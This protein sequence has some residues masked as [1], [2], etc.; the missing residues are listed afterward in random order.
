MSEIGR[1]DAGADRRQPWNEDKTPGSKSPPEPR[2]I[3]AIRT[4]LQLEGRAR[5]L[6]LF[7]LAID[8]N[9][10][11]GDVVSLKI[12]DVAPHGSILGSSTVRQKKTGRPVKLEITEQARVAIA[13]YPGS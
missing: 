13:E 12:E 5:D 8:S 11:G 10:R 3:W 2:D 7:D 4:R 1:P 6:A 9:P